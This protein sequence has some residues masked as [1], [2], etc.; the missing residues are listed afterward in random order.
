M[1]TA[2]K[3]LQ[4]AIK[5]DNWTGTRFA[6]SNYDKPIRFDKKRD[7]TAGET[8][9]FGL[10][11]SVFFENCR[12]TNVY[13]SKAVILNCEMTLKTDRTNIEP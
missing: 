7:E 13:K 10:S 4:E 12:R 3:G 2:Y 1:P 8:K 5:G 6:K 11:N 9:S